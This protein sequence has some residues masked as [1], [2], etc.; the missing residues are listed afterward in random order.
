MRE[1]ESSLP[2]SLLLFLLHQVKDTTERRRDLS[3]T[4]HIVSSPRLGNRSYQSTM[5]ILCSTPAI[6]L[7]KMSLFFALPPLL[8]LSFLSSSSLSSFSHSSYLIA[9]S[10]CLFADELLDHLLHVC[11]LLLNVDRVQIG[12]EAG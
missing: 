6:T 11:V 10:P 7:V 12:I 8:S 2:P 3:I 9:H 5:T 1:S 4:P